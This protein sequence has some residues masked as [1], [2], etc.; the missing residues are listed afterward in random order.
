MLALYIIVGLVVILILLLCIPVQTIVIVDTESS[1]KYSLIVSW[2]FGIVKKDLG[3]RR[4]KQIK[5]TKIPAKKKR[6]PTRLD[7]DF[8][9]RIVNAAGL[10]KRFKELTAGIYRQLKIKEISGDLVVGLEDP[11]Y[12]GMLFAVI[13]PA[14]ALLNLHPRYNVCIRP[15]FD[16]E[17]ILKGNLYGNI[18]VR[19]IRLVGPVLTLAAS[20]EVRRIGKDYMKKK[21]WRGGKSN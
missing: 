9:S 14:N 7:V 18:K 21:W 2:L 19:P 1:K 4:P 3:E 15:F 17:N 20:K 5:K 10:I 16:D 12:T 13:G 6:V 11:A 8:V